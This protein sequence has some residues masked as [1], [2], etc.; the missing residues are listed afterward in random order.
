MLKAV[1]FDVDGV[2]IDLLRQISFFI[3]KSCVIN[4]TVIQFSLVYEAQNS[5]T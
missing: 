5:P 2:L 1:I 3:L 4:Q